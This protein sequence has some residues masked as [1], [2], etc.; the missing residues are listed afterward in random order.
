MIRSAHSLTR[1]FWFLFKCFF[2][3][4]I[5]KISISRWTLFSSYFNSICCFIT[6]LSSK[7]FE[8]SWAFSSMHESRAYSSTS[9]FSADDIWIVPIVPCI[10]KLLLI[11]FCYVFYLG[12][13]TPRLLG[14]YFFT[15]ESNATSLD[16]LLWSTLEGIG[17]GDSDKA[18]G[19]FLSNCKFSKSGSKL[20][21]VT[22][23]FY[24]FSVE[25]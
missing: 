12:S 13:G 5:F 14:G 20:S 10:R 7:C 4:S 8:K 22:L 17:R 15:S 25:W 1:F 2:S 11:V 19:E 3:S 24:S 6:R 9:E 23:G 18:P 16:D 21:S